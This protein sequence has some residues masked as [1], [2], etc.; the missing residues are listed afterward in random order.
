[1]VATE[2]CLWSGARVAM[3]ISWR[4]LG[5]FLQRLEKPVDEL[6]FPRGSDPLATP[7]SGLDE[8]PDEDTNHPAEHESDDEA[9]RQFHLSEPRDHCPPQDVRAVSMAGASA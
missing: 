5:N 8:R 1:M 2:Y 3:L 9:D 6:G 4:S 7:Q